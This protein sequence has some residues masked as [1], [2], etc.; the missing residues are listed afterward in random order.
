MGLFINLAVLNFPPVCT[1]VGREGGVVKPGAFAVEPEGP[2][3]LV[4]NL[5]HAAYSPLL[6]GRLNGIAQASSPS[7]DSG[8][9]RVGKSLVSL[10]SCM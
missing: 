8:E 2:C 6:A 5:Q 4:W 3:G 7:S 10:G 1:M 9:E